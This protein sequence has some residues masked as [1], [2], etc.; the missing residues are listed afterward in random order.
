MNLRDDMVPVQVQDVVEE[1]DKLVL[2]ELTEEFLP[3]WRGLRLL[4][5]P[6][7]EGAPGVLRPPTGSRP[8][9]SFIWKNEK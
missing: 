1:V 4:L 5:G 2:L 7:D 9:A 8:P 6:A 3:Q